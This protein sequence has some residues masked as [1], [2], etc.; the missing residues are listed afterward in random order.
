MRAHFLDA[1]RVLVFGT[2]LAEEDA[3]G[4]YSFCCCKCLYADREWQ[5]GLTGVVAF[6]F[7]YT[8]SAQVGTAPASNTFP[9]VALSFKYTSSAQGMN[10]GQ[11]SCYLGLVLSS[12]ETVQGQV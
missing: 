9:G 8:S 12:P 4:V 5:I 2:C 1:G 7:K 10:T 3:H 6:S 11:R